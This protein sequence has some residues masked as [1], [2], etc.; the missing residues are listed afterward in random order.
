MTTHFMSASV[1]V[2]D[3]GPQTSCH[4]ARLY[5]VTDLGPHKL[6]PTKR[7]TERWRFEVE[8]EP[9]CWELVDCHLPKWKHPRSARTQF[10][11]RW[12]GEDLRPAML[13]KPEILVGRVALVE[14][15]TSVDSD[16]IM[17]RVVVSARP[18]PKPIHSPGRTADLAGPRG[19]DG[20][21]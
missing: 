18:N 3:L 16:G 5:E 21:R 17:N 7:P 15:R 19:E 13:D 10:L 1:D 20:G 6:L 8:I 12:L 14:V 9:G 11:T 2:A 4:D